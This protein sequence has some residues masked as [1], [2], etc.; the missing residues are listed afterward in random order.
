MPTCNK[1]FYASSFFPPTSKLWNSL[2]SDC[3]LESYKCRI[4]GNV[5]RYLLCL[6]DSLWFPLRV[7]HCHELAQLTCSVQ[8]IKK[9]E[10]DLLNIVILE[11]YSWV[12]IKRGGAFINF[13]KIFTPP[14]TLFCTPS[15]I[16]FHKIILVIQTFLSLQ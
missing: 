6:S 7:G 9:G 13:S 5:N 10:I 12:H 11:E 8:S 3:F 16:N 14:R 4:S 2:L 15:F 1:P